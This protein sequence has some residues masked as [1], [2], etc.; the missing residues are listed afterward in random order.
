MKPAKIVQAI[1]KDNPELLAQIPEQ[2]AAL[3]VREALTRIAREV[4]AIEAGVIK[5]PGLGRFKTKQ[6][7]R[8][9]SGTKVK[10]VSFRLAKAKKAPTE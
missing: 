3:L 7:E 1:K 9:E 2:K 8:K 10:K 6:V 4:T 5:V